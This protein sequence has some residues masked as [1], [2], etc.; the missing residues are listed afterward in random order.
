M[1]E[2]SRIVIERY[3]MTHKSAKSRRLQKLVNMSYDLA[4]EGTD[5]DAIWLANAIDREEDDELEAAM[6]D[7]DDF[8]FGF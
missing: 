1:D 5:A 6:K 8:L 7:L 3:C 4:A 2:W